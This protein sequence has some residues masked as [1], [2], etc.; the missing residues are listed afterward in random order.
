[1][2]TKKQIIHEGELHLGETTIPCYILEDGTRVLSGLGMQNALKIQEPTEIVSG[3][4]LARY[5]GQKTLEPFIYKEKE[6]GHFEPIICYKG[7]SKI[8]GYEATI[9]ADICESFLDARNHIKLS[10]RQ[11]VIAEQCEILI[12]GFAKV[13]IVALVDEATGYQYEREKDA[14]QIIL[15][16]YINEELLKWQKKFPDMF[17]VEIFRLNKWDYTV[18]GIN[19]RPGVIGKWTNDLI[20]SQ[21]PNGVLEELKRITPKSEEGNYTARFFQS[22]T[23]NLGHPELTAQIYKVIGIMNISATWDEF[24]SHFNRMIDR[25]SGQMEIDFDSINPEE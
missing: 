15:K 1:M 16:A 13:G 18:K 17:Y 3:S 6:P 2:A 22:L 10:P 12:R 9:L 8:N 14:L 11:N 20:Y 7:E 4:R 23:P 19:K 25:S 21:L 24:K 5:L